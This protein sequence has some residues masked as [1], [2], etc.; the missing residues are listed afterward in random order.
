MNENLHDPD[1]VPRSLDLDR[2]F[3]RS[4]G[5]GNR[6]PIRLAII[7]AGSM[8]AEHAE[9]VASVGEA[10]VVGVVDPN[11]SCVEYTLREIPDRDA[12]T[13][14]D[15]PEAAAA[16]DEVD[17]LIVATPN[18]THWDIVRRVL[19]YKKHLLVEK[20][21]TTT[22]EDAVALADAVAEYPAV[23]YVGLEIRFKPF[24]QEV[25]HEV[26][27]RRSVGEVKM[28][29][30]MEHRVPFLEKWQQWNKFQ[31]QSGGTLVEKCCH[32]FDLF[33]LLAESRP[34]RVFG[35]G[36]QDVAYRDYE[37]GGQR[38]D[39]IDNAFVTVDY[40]NG[41]RACLNLCM[42][43]QRGCR[44]Q[45][46]VNGDRA[47]LYASN[48]PEDRIEVVTGGDELDRVVTAKANP[49]IAATG[50]HAGA[51]YYEHVAFYDCI[52]NGGRPVADAVDG[53]WSVVIGALAEQSI[54]EGR[55]IE[56]PDS[57]ARFAQAAWE[58]KRA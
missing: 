41:V 46:I 26:R 30:I 42:F 10:K 34:V 22:V 33:N 38:S 48:T 2:V 14:Y 19:P 27:R 5:A 56:V 52:R 31:E 35:T 58:T 32:F 49:K 17:G 51:T 54:Q 13:V 50:T 1:Y 45:I 12:V 28:I 55:P 53:L 4:N 44:E 16:S 3:G 7:G 8:G 47:S 11:P 21:M 37:Y 15:T 36:A 24:I 6:E 9:T 57:L 40:A 20:P 43:N 25:L 39:I 23:F 18:N 29:S